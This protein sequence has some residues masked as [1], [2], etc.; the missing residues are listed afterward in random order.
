MVFQD[1]S[2]IETNVIMRLRKINLADTWMTLAYPGLGRFA[3]VPGGDFLGCRCF[4]DFEA[5]PG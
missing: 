1:Q 5:V 2:K 4:Q 3:C